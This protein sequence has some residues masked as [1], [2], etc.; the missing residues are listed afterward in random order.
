MTLRIHAIRTGVVAIKQNQLAAASD[1]PMARL[2]TIMDK[3]WTDPLP[4]FAWVIEHPEGLIVIDTGETARTAEPGYFPGWHPY[5][6]F[7]VRLSVLPEQE[8]GPQ[9]ALLGLSPRDVRWVVM[10]HM[11]TDHAG[12][13]HHFPQAEILVGRT[14]LEATR[15]FPGLMQGYL[16][17]RWPTE[18]RPRAVD[19]IPSPQGPWSTSYP[20]T[21]AGDVVLL[22]TPGHSPGHLSVLVKENDRSLLIAGDASYNQTLML[23][24]KVDGVSPNHKVARMTLSKIHEYVTSVPTVYL[25][26]HDPHSANRLRDREAV[27]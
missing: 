15:G 26:S 23:Q 1:G 25:P 8:I 17:H 14:E 2:Q 5:Y 10:T 20:L 11:H 12:G 7:G 18:F 6:R 3:R 13:L 24:Q 16:P 21:K 19:F 4:I 9:M 22:P 27:R